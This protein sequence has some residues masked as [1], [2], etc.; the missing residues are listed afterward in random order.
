[1]TVELG[2]RVLKIEANAIQ[3]VAESLD[4]AFSR[5]VDI[6]ADCRGK[7]VVTGMGKSGI[8]C[9]KIAATM[10]STGTPAIFMHPAEAIHGDLGIIAQGDVVLAVSYS[11]ET[12]EVIRLLEF[13]QRQGILL[14]A[15]TGN[16]ESTLGRHAKS[17]IS[18]RVSKEACPLN[19]APTAS[20]T[21]A[22]AV[23][24]ALSIA[25]S[26]RKGFREEDFALRHPGGKL[27][28][29][30]MRVRDLMHTGDALPRVQP[31]TNMK[32]VIYEMSRKGFGITAVVDDQNALLG[33]ISDGDLR[34]FLQRDNAILQKTA[35][36]CMK[37]GAVTIGPDILASE[38]LKHLEDRRIT[39]LFITDDR[40]VLEGILHIHDLWGVGFF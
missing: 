27:G 8:I 18:A 38:A 11:G 33:V 10:S 34:R 36:E 13:L 3:D 4:E 24:D 9:R 30:L 1:M 2:K 37:A 5:A 16:P 29:K 6:L 19:L 32:D 26:I 22:L 15:I 28:K 21:A 40:K 14:I 31:G 35:G 7:V 25:L 20:T 17:H 39:S 12:E 23:G